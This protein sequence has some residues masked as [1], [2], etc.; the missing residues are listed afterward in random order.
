MQCKSKIEPDHVDM[1]AALHSDGVC[2]WDPAAW[3][4]GSELSIT[5]RVSEPTHPTSK[6][7]M[8]GGGSYTDNSVMFLS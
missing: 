8:V 5:W 2:T 6:L 1:L 7:D 3:I 4:S